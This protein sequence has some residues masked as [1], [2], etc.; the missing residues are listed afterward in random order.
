MRSTG[1]NGYRADEMRNSLER[2]CGLRG[3]LGSEFYGLATRPAGCTGTLCGR[4]PKSFWS[5][6]PGCGG[7][8]RCRPG[9][10]R[11]G[12][13]CSGLVRFNLKNKEDKM[14]KT[15]MATTS[16][17]K[18]AKIFKAR[19]ESL[20]GLS[21]DYLILATSPKSAIEIASALARRE[22]S[23]P[24]FESLEVVGELRN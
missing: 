16:G 10:Q 14:E 5:D 23:N 12:K 21:S 9:A 11:L 19:F 20:L 8:A 24:Q 2:F 15:A 18:G 1:R 6:E 7:Q 13:V 4:S 17:R 3:R 22:L